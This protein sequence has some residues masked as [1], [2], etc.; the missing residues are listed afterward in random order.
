M[1][2]NVL[3][4][5]SPLAKY[6]SDAGENVLVTDAP[7]LKA[8]KEEEDD[9][10]AG[11]SRWLFRRPIA[12]AMPEF[13]AIYATMMGSE[14]RHLESDFPDVKSAL[15]EERSEF[16]V[17]W[18]SV[19]MCALGAAV[20]LLLSSGVGLAVVLVWWWLFVPSRNP[21]IVREVHDAFARLEKQV[22]KSVS[23]V[24]EVELVSRGYRVG[25]TVQS[26]VS[27]VEASSGM[28]DGDRFLARLRK[29]VLVE[30]DCVFSAVEQLLPDFQAS[31]EVDVDEIRRIL[32]ESHEFQDVTLQSLAVQFRALKLVQVCMCT[33][34]LRSILLAPSR[35]VR[36]HAEHL[37]KVCAKSAGRV[38]DARLIDWKRKAS[39][40]GQSARNRS[41]PAIGALQAGL[42]TIGAKT[43]LLE[44]LLKQGKT[45]EAEL[46]R[47]SVSSELSRLLRDWDFDWKRPKV[48]DE[49]VSGASVPFQPS[50]T[51]TVE[52]G[53]L[54]TD[55]IGDVQ[56]ESRVGLPHNQQI[57]D[58]LKIYEARIQESGEEKNRVPVMS[59]EERIREMY[60][61]RA[62]EERAQ[63]ESRA[64]YALID[65]LEN[66]LQKK[67]K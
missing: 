16:F 21:K 56:P 53:G 37:V 4:S 17:P 64:V 10:N 6:L 58:I 3:F 30:L 52:M 29:T 8:K 23:L 15:R 63:A 9:D 44:E 54:Q 51:E 7:E 36:M 40:R 26:P 57:E 12:N 67:K 50:R 48:C 25:A 27:L 39:D 60:E 43:V 41:E 47:A 46:E 19:G 38:S 13:D 49:V 65:E 14:D 66:V 31:F 11:V 28:S 33:L 59:R 20:A 18:Q 2:Q 42:R 35:K 45:E 32:K 61:R 55:V 22:G 34:M 24:R 62:R 1:E 5:D